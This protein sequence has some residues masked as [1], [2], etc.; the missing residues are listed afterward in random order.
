MLRHFWSSEV[1]FHIVLICIAALV[2]VCPI[3]HVVVESNSSL[4]TVIFRCMMHQKCSLFVRVN[5]NFSIWNWVNRFFVVFLSHALIVEENVSGAGFT[6]L[7]SFNQQR[8]SVD[9]NSEHNK[10]HHPIVS[11]FVHPCLT[12]GVATWRIV[13]T[14]LVVSTKL[15]YFE[16]GEYWDGWPCP[17]STPG[18]GT[19][20]WYVTSHPSRLSLLPYVGR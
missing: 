9:G 6:G 10:E 12:R 14:A 13:V 16:P 17:G 2:V 19:L 15:L 7:S 11:S 4:L 8:R 18:G 20:F 1:I 5:S 3:C